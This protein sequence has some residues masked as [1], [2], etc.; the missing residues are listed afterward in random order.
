ME[1]LYEKFEFTTEG[2]S[3]RAMA[4]I[5]FWKGVKP[6]RSPIDRA[7]KQII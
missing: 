5:E 3:K 1:K 2:V 4:T 7:F 6:I